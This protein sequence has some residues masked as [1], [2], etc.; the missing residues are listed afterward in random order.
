MVLLLI[1]A[2][3]ALLFSFFCSLAEAVMLSMTPFY[4]QSMVRKGHRSARL[5][6]S[7]TRNLDQALAA[8]LS[9]NTIAHTVGA[10][11][12]GA[13]AAREFGS[14]YVGIASA[15]LTLLILFLS[16]IIPK[17]IGAAWWRTLG[18]MI[19]PAVWLLVRLLWP[20]VWLAERLTLL[21]SRGRP[22]TRFRREELTAMAEVGAKEGQLHPDE[23]RIVRHLLRFRTVRAAEIMTPRIVMFTLDQHWTVA[24]T[25]TRYPEIQFSRI[26]LH[27]KD[28]D[29]V[30][31]F[32]FKADLYLAGAQDRHDLMLSELARPLTEV[33]TTMPIW[34]LLEVL[35]S[36]TQHISILI[37]EYGGV[38]G[39]VTLED[40]IET[41]LGFEII[42]ELD[43][44]TDM[45]ELARQRWKKRA[46]NLRVMDA[47]EPT[48][49]ES[50]SHARTEETPNR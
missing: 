41:L 22:G 35:T 48:S 20:L 46:A 13:E 4:V 15:V 31:T 43:T 34:A 11:G 42:D 5:L 32:L 3:V 25:L 28:P 38:A 6:Q 26:P 47:G 14:A 44:T 17:S 27:G 30:N 45:Q 37:D 18:P 12:V 1:Y 19:A 9:L 50:P 33:S 10:V 16:E 8:I 49:R 7:L 2:G 39:L 40:I 21:V 36:D 23:L 29:D 24:E